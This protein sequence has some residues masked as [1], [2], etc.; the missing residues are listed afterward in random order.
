MDDPA[1]MSPAMHLSL[2]WWTR[3]RLRGMNGRRVHLRVRDRAH[4]TGRDARARAPCSLEPRPLQY[5]SAHGTR[6]G[7]EDDRSS[8]LVNLSTYA[9]LLASTH[10]ARDGTT[11]FVRGARTIIRSRRSF[12]T[13][14]VLA[15]PRRIASCGTSA[16]WK[17]SF[18]AAA[19]SPI[20]LFIRNA[21]EQAI[22]APK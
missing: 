22:P 19:C 13:S 12:R 21:H 2:I 16:S 17:R 15:R 18:A 8:S 3:R 11:S 9:R 10:R 4:T 1:L 5:G 6:H 14:A 7:T 20:H